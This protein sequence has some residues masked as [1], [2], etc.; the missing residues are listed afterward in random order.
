MLRALR[1]LL[2]YSLVC[3]ILY[4]LL[5]Y[6]FNTPPSKKLSAALLNLNRR[7]NAAEENETQ[8]QLTD[9]IS[10]INSAMKANRE[11]DQELVEISQY[12]PL[13]LLH[14]LNWKGC[15]SISLIW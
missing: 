6:T 11:I 2:K 14:S 1:R 8:T 3:A 5:S 4:L 15:A 10:R 9:V 12:S 7:S 13:A